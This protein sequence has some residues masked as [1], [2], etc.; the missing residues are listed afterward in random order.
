[1][2]NNLYIVWKKEYNTGIAI[3]DEQH[4]GIISTINSL[5]HF[6]QNG[7]GEDILE[8]TILIMEQYI[9]I[10]FQTEEA[11]LRKANYLKYDEHILLH[12]KWSERTKMLTLKNV[13]EPAEVLKFL[14]QWWMEHIN[15]EDRK[16]ISSL[17]EILENNRILKGI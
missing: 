2:N 15:I 14:K 11:L 4:R 17:N 12:R 7:H 5:Y 9:N 1:M 3:I 13:N 8:S 10:H 6:I 16:Y